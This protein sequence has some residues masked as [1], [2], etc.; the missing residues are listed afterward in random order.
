MS[1]QVLIVIYI[2]KYSCFY[3]F[4]YPNIFYQNIQD[5]LERCC[6][7][8]TSV[9]ETAWEAKAIAVIGCISDTDVSIF[10]KIGIKGL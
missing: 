10:N 9:F 7:R 4:K 1:K 3:E 5:L 2:L 8:S 6:T